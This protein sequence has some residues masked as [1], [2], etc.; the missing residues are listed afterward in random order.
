MADLKI[1]I[2][3]GGGDNA[4]SEIKKITSATGGLSDASKKL[5][6]GSK[7][8]GDAIEQFGKRGSAAKDAFEG[9]TTA[10][11]GGAG[12]IFGLSKA[13]L[14]LKDAF[15][16]NPITAALGAVLGL[17]GL[18]KAGFD[19]V[20]DRAVAARDKMFGTGEKTLALKKELESVAAASAQAIAAMQTEVQ[21]LLDAYTALN[22]ELNDV[23]ANFKKIET[24]K[25]NAEI[26]GLEAQRQQALD[27]PGA[28]PEAINR[29]FDQRIAAAKERSALNVA[30]RETGAARIRKINAEEVTAAI[31]GK[32]IG[33]TRA[34]D[35]ADVAFTSAIDPTAQAKAR[36]Q[37]EM[38]EDALRI[39]DK[40]NN[41]K[42]AAARSTIAEADATIEASKFDDTARQLKSMAGDRRQA[43]ER[44]TAMARS[45]SSDLGPTLRNARAERAPFSEA[46]YFS[47]E[48]RNL[49]RARYAAGAAPFAAGFAEAKAKA[50]AIASKL[51][52]G[53][54]DDTDA[55]ELIA[56]L[57]RIIRATDQ[58]SNGS[59][60]EI[61]RRLTQLEAAIKN[62]R[63]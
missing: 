20:G 19:L 31:E 42:L 50:E 55:R 12:A 13:W 36:R 23:T 24:A 58:T 57:D 15:A 29:Q 41:P 46:G 28:D 8:S 10:T 9:L 5:A 60:K 54:N 38:A 40:D 37:R 6:T 59:L 1:N 27:K 7:E 17:L 21:S 26:A 35:Q 34:V 22:T 63:N 4:A 39:F 11:N 48:T 49:D 2:T 32:R 45:I 53:Q 33:F 51:G 62:A 3:A 18:I 52:D 47:E 14:N 25:S 56:T 43:R 44:S 61:Q 16:A 30:N